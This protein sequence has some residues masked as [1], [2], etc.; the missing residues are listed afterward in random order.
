MGQIQTSPSHT[1]TRG[2]RRAN[3]LSFTKSISVHS[4]CEATFF[5][6]AEW[7]SDSWVVGSPKKLQYYATFPSSSSS[8]LMTPGEPC[9]RHKVSNSVETQ[10]NYLATICETACPVMWKGENIRCNILIRRVTKVRI[11][12][13]GYD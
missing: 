4:K 12:E 5:S 8:F 7:P 11:V 2:W 10:L 1:C 13:V 6:L 9:L 3:I